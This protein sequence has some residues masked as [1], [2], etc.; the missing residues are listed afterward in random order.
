MLFTLTKIWD[1][2]L[3]A[4]ERD[5][6]GV[7]TGRNDAR[8]LRPATTNASGTVKSVFTHWKFPT[9]FLRRCSTATIS[10]RNAAKPIRRRSS[11]V[12]P[13]DAKYGCS[14]ANDAQCQ[15]GQQFPA[16]H[17]RNEAG[18]SPTL[19]RLPVR[20][21]PLLA[22][23]NDAQWSHAAVHDVQSGTQRLRTRWLVNS[24]R[25]SLSNDDARWFEHTCSVYAV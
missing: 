21:F 16:G 8:F 24:S 23:P 17:E 1:L 4:T 2:V 3:G 20:H 25:P 5:G 12:F 7:G 22:E 10:R 13:R 11:H 19:Y 6:H 9:N 15:N 18:I 14:T